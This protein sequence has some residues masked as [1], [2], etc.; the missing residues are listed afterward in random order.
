MDLILTLIQ[1]GSLVV[2]FVILYM[3][4]REIKPA[5]LNDSWN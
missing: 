3:A 1:F 4:W 5:I 2:G